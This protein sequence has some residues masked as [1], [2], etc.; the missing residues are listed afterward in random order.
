MSDDDVVETAADDVVLQR[1]HG[2]DDDLVAAAV[3][4]GEAVAVEPGVRVQDDVGGG[5]VA[6]IEGVGAV[7][8]QR[9]R[10]ADVVT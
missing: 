7:L 10:E 2:G 8:L 1:V 4:E 3:G 6:E 5:V 9:G